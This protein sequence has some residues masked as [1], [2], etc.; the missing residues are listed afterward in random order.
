MQLIYS[1]LC[2]H[3]ILCEF[4]DMIRIDVPTHTYMKRMLDSAMQQYDLSS[5]KSA[6]WVIHFDISYEGCYQVSIEATRIKSSPFLDACN[7]AFNEINAKADNYLPAQNVWAQANEIIMDVLDT[8]DKFSSLTKY[9]LA[10]LILDIHRSEYLKDNIV[11]DYI[12]TD[13]EIETDPLMFIDFYDGRAANVS[14]WIRNYA[15]FLIE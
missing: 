11:A 13:T 7:L 4:A 14:K 1:I 5:L 3:Q 15:K 2:F 12:P 8:I 10:K 9:Q 6:D